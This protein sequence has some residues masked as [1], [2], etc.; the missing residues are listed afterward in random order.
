MPQG[1]PRPPALAAF[2][3]AFPTFFF[4]ILLF[5]GGGGSARAPSTPRLYLLISR[6]LTYSHAAAPR[7]PAVASC[8]SPRPTRPDL[9]TGNFTARPGGVS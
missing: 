2:S 8:N 1:A 4:I 9:R 6:P 5:F 3:E 7:G